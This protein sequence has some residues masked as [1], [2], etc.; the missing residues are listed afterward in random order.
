MIKYFLPLLL[1]LSYSAHAQLNTAVP[2]RDLESWSY[3]GVQ[4]KFSDE[5]SL[6]LYQGLRLYD[7]SSNVNQVLTE[8]SAKV[9]ASDMLSFGGGL[10]YIRN[11]TN[12]GD[13][14]NNMRFNFDVG[15]KHKLERFTFKY[16]LRFQTRNELGYSK[17]E[18]DF[19]VNG[20]RLKAG[21]KYNIR[22]WKLDPTFSTEIF[23]ESGKYILSSYEKMRFTLGTKYKIKKVGEA[24]L[25]YRLEKDLGELYPLT[26]HIWGLNFTFKL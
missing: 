23:R 16:R 24:G 5:F 21:V 3:V 26:A 25:F 7:N 1:L 15:L 19:A 2:V 6:K 13:F 12:S 14:E 10:R 17:S 22:K 4:K 20:Q 8:L 9:N 11:R 18:G